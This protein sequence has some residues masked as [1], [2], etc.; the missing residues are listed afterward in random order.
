MD[1]QL[2]VVLLLIIAASAFLAFQTWRG[3]AKG[4]S[5][6][7]GCGSGCKTT[8]VSKDNNVFIPAS[9]LL[10]RRRDNGEDTSRN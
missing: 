7:G 1:G 6:C 2:I 8:P 10:L 5:S 4:K 3:W 9:Q